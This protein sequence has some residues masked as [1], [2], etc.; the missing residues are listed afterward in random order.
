[1]FPR[2]RPRTLSDNDSDGFGDGYGDGYGDESIA[3]VTTLLIFNL[4]VAHVV[5]NDAGSST[6]CDPS[7]SDASCCPERSRR[8]LAKVV[9]FSTAVRCV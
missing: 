5:G 3:E 2:D 6:P 9:A 4:L 1:M 7:A 8:Q